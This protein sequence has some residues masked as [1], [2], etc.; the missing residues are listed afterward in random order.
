MTREL[1]RILERDPHPTLRSLVTNVS[2]AL[3][4]MSLE[5]HLETLRYKRAIKTYNKL[6]LEQQQRRNATAA[7]S[8]TR[9]ANAHSQTT[10]E[11]T[12]APVTPGATAPVSRASSRVIAPV[13]VSET[14]DQRV[15]S[16]MSA[17]AKEGTD[18]NAENAVRKPTP[19]QAKAK[20]KAK[21]EGFVEIEPTGTYDMDNFQDPQVASHRPLDME[22]PWSM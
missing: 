2:H 7:G 21:S 11:S 6:V 20:T 12:L 3:H 22:R 9:G 1:V 14:E 18:A 13:R 15:S 19:P 5:R 4:R 10:V 17:G 8:A 16:E